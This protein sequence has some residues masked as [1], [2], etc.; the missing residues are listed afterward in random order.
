[1]A[2]KQRP[3]GILPVMDS[4]RFEHELALNLEPLDTDKHVGFHT[5]SKKKKKKK[6]LE[7]DRYHQCPSNSHTHIARSFM[8]KI[9]IYLKKL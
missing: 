9:S 5:G 2:K 7:L 1:M 6:K 4:E 8:L 3:V